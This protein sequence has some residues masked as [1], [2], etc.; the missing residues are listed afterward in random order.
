MRSMRWIA[1]GA[2]ATPTGAHWRSGACPPT[3]SSV[4]SSG[5]RFPSLS[6]RRTKPCCASLPMSNALSCSKRRRPLPV[7]GF[8]S[9]LRRT[10]PAS[11]CFGG[12]SPGAGRPSKCCVRTRNICGWRRRQRASARGTGTFSPTIST[13]RQR[14]STCSAANRSTD[15]P[16]IC[17]RCGRRRCIRMTGRK[18]KQTPVRTGRRHSRSS[19]SSASSVRMARC[20]GSPLAATCC[21]TSSASPVA[22]SASTSTSPTAS[23]PRRHWS[24]AC[25]NARGPCSR[26]SPRCRNHAPATAQSSNMRRWT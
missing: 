12:T 20:A 1:T 9:P 10:T 4:V 14:C 2:S 17:S 21:R 23:A 13:G 3:R 5:T 11:R 6:E 24:S 15:R 25:G 19:R 8:T 16:P 22:W 26:H 18:P 7:R